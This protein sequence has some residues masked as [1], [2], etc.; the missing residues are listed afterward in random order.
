MD[1]G[2]PVYEEIK[3][4]TNVGEKRGQMKKPKR[5]ELKLKYKRCARQKQEQRSSLKSCA[6]SSR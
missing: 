2:A 3:V 5:I 4:K 6:N 1:S